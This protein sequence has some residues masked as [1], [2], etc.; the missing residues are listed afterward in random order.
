[1][2]NETFCLVKEASEDGLADQ[3]SGLNSGALLMAAR[4]LE[5]T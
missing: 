1:M 3:A 4:P 5:A 2:G